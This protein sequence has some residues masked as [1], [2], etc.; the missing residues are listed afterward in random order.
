MISTNF[1]EFSN[2][3]MW[4]TGHFYFY[5]SVLTSFRKKNNSET[6]PYYTVRYM[7]I[8]FADGDY[9]YHQTYVIMHH[10]LYH[11]MS[12]VAPILVTAS[13]T[14]T[15]WRAQVSLYLFYTVSQQGDNQCANCDHK[16]TKYIHVRH[17]TRRE[18]HVEMLHVTFCDLSGQ[19]NNKLKKTIF[20]LFKTFVIFSK[21]KNVL[22][23]SWNQEKSS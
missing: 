19:P 16:T 4:K 12:G 5:H 1:C 18:F 14:L 17:E 23:W 21:K 3:N 15:Y 6:F 13:G 2:I 8:D 20:L 7:P 22:N 10:V 9:H 11:D